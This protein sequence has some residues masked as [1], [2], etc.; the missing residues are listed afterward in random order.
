LNTT[1]TQIENTK[2]VKVEIFF[3]VL[4]AVLFIGRASIPELKYP[5]IVTFRQ[6]LRIK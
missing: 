6:H 2:V 3:S 5:F 4:V 1:I